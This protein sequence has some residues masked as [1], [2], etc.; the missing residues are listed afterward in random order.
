MHAPPLSY[1]PKKN[2]QGGLCSILFRFDSIPFSDL[3]DYLENHTT[4]T[5]T[6]FTT[7][8]IAFHSIRHERTHINTYTKQLEIIQMKSRIQYSINIAVVVEVNLVSKY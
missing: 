6:S 4:T 2:H 7:R 5:T 8:T 1:Y 3:W